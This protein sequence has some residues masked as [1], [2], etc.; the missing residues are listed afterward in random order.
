[1]LGGQPSTKVHTGVR[2][3]STLPF[4]STDL[5][6]IH[7]L[8]SFCDVCNFC[9]GSIGVYHCGPG[10]YYPRPLP[11]PARGGVLERPARSEPGTTEE[12]GLRTGEEGKKSS[13]GEDG[14]I[15]TEEKVPSPTWDGGGGPP[16]ETEETGHPTPPG[17][18][19]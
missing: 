2:S 14:P 13:E 6:L 9:Y 7:F 1:M 11:P 10:L 17:V 4:H 16:E 15:G 12:V 19:Q 5:Y 18:N 3:V 8:F